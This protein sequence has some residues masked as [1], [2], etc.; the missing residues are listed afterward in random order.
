MF[1]CH[2]GISRSTACALTYLTIKLG[3]GSEEECVEKIWEVRPIAWFNDRIVTIADALLNRNGALVKAVS[4]WK[5]L[6]RE[7]R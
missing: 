6:R 7:Y 5:E 2:A 1:H 3:P 4:D